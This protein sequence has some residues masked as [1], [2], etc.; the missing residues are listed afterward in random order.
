[1]LINAF[2]TTQF[3]YCISLVAGLSSSIIIST[4]INSELLCKVIYLLW[5]IRQQDTSS[6]SKHLVNCKLNSLPS[7][8]PEQSIS[9][10]LLTRSLIL[11][12]S[13]L[14]IE[15]KKML[16]ERNTLTLSLKGYRNN[17]KSS[18]KLMREQRENSDGGVSIH[19]YKKS[20]SPSRIGTQPRE[21]REIYYV[22]TALISFVPLIATVVLE[23]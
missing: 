10:T 15:K 23:R 16:V 21:I 7:S 13:D 12:V 1:M 20:I 5:A 19:E 18:L 4:P 22:P 14:L 9:V 3:D 2:V 6:I 17:S 8:L 11:V